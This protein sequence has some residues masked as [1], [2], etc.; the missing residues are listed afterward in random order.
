M[1]EQA[2]GWAAAVVVDGGRLKAGLIWKFAA[3]LQG[4]VALW[5]ELRVVPDSPTEL[6]RF[7]LTRCQPRCFFPHHPIPF[8]GNIARFDTISFIIST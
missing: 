3:L 8:T 5:R 4:G 2:V 1:R 7:Q 6:I